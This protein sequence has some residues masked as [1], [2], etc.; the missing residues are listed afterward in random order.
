MSEIK[1]KFIKD[2]A[3]ASDFAQ[4]QEEVKK[5]RFELEKKKVNLEF[6]EVKKNEEELRIA[7][8]I[9]LGNLTLNQID[10]IRKDNAEYME[11]AKNPMKFICN[12]FNDVVPYFRKN[13]IVIAAPTGQGK[14]TIVANLAM[15]TMAQKN[16]QTGKR[17]RVLV[18]SNEEDPG[19][20][21]N[22][23]T[24]LI[25]GFSYTNHGD[26]TEEQRKMLDETIPVLA[27][28]G[29]LTI[30]GNSYAND[31]GR[32]I[33]GLT[34]TVEGIRTIFDSLLKNN[35][36]FSVVVIDYYQNISS[37]KENVKLDQ[38]KSQ[39]KFCSYL[40]EIKNIYPAPIV[41]L[42]QIKKDDEDTPYN[43]RIKG[44]KMLADKAT[45][46][47]EMETDIE[48]HRTKCSVRKGRYIKSLG[49]EFY[50]GYDR[51]KFVDYD[52]KFQT[53]VNA[54]KE[55]KQMAFIDKKE[56]KNGNNS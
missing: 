30:I 55:Q 36:Y 20:L 27:K 21:Y 6:N 32:V 16:P 3:E 10:R 2:F 54:R 14:S 46:F 35:E 13:C 31:D 33:T 44:A 49:K 38:Y 26:F 11:A 47:I 15:S 17:G 25:K 56:E 19:D 48:N 29:W 4:A 12:T 1:E 28:D 22:R 5:K 24:S 53:T 23:V 50:I 37:S 7:E 9:N 34:N 42:A 41:V 39:E 8:S 43:I 18:I 40:D 45:V 51:G 52:I